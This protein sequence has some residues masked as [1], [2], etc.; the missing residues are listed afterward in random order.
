[1]IST[2]EYSRTN[3]RATHLISPGAI[4]HLLEDNTDR[5]SDRAEFC[6]DDVVVVNKVVWRGTRWSAVLVQLSDWYSWIKTIIVKIIRLRPNEKNQVVIK[7]HVAHMKS[8]KFSPISTVI[9]LQTPRPQV[10]KYVTTQKQNWSGI[11]WQSCNRLP[12]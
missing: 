12:I 11:E 7:R 6:F 3:N 5:F 10:T 4:V 9:I 8:L 2:I 1:M